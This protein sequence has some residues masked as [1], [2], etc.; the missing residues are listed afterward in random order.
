MGGKEILPV[1]DKNSQAPQ[2]LRIATIA[3]LTAVTF[4]IGYFV[5]FPLP[6]S[7]GTFTLVDLGVFFAAFAF[8]PFSAAIAGGA[9]SAIFDLAS[10][11]AAYA[12]ISL[13][14]HGLE[15]LIAGL[16]AT[17]GYR[18]PLE[19]VLW[20]V[21]GL[22]G[23]GIVIGGYFLAQ[24]VLFGGPAMALKEVLFNAVQAGVGAVA[25][26][27]LTVAVRRAYPP[28]QGLRW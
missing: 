14:V 20:A 3:V 1:Q 27:L 6:A 28:V 15:G 4:V 2:T 19:A 13:V 25:G 12:P 18:K 8:G 7:G 21:A 16:I 10:G 17:A 23:T 26:A 11:Y 9:G 5:R 24:I 22:I